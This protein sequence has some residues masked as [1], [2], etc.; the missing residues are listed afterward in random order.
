MPVAER[1]CR[2]EVL[3]DASP[4]WRACERSL[5]TAGVRLP[6]PHRAGWKLARRGIEMRCVALRGPDGVC[7]GAFG[8]SA[9]ASRVLPGFRLLRVDRFGEAVPNALWAAAV[10]ALATV[11]RK[12]PRAL[13]LTVEV[14]SRDADTRAR[15]GELLGQ[16]GFARATTCRNGSTTLTLDLWPSEEQLFAS[17][18]PPARQAIRA[19]PKFP[20]QVRLIEDPELGNRLDALSRETFAR[21]GGRYEALWDWAGVIDLSRSVPNAARLV[22]LFRTDR[23]GPDA[24]LGF[25][26][27]WWNGQ[28]VTNFAICVACPLDIPCCGI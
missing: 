14:F 7:A 11:A 5:A 21:T 19:I 9:A 15:I 13:L 17:L 25:A 24:L 12:E 23:E 6:L 3:E 20:V 22:G 28:S 27:A 16:A 18:R 10:D 8:V 2:V 26:W 4:E 1:G